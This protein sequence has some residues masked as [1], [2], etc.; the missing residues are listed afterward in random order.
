M[1]ILSKLNPSVSY[2]FF[3][4]CRVSYELIFSRSNQF[5]SARYSFPGL[6]MIGYGTGKINL[7]LAP[8][9]QLNC[10]AFSF[11]YEFPDVE[12]RFLI[13]IQKGSNFKIIFPYPISYITLIFTNSILIFICMLC[14]YIQFYVQSHKL[15]KVH[16]S[17]YI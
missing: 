7:K 2:G 16:K 15:T 13:E 4:A 6:Y 12:L 17:I 9:C 1:H 14:V 3:K 8:F 10:F 5:F 11:S